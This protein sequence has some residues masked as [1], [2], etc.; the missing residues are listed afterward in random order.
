MVGEDVKRVVFHLVELWFS[1]GG[2]PFTYPRVLQRDVHRQHAHRDPKRY[3]MATPRQLSNRSAILAI[4]A[5]CGRRPGSEA[6]NGSLLHVSGLY[7]PEELRRTLRPRNRLPDMRS[8]KSACTAMLPR[9]LT[10]VG[11]DSIGHRCLHTFPQGAHA[12]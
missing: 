5:P 12:G 1:G 9:F 8:T 6:P 3:T 2:G 4:L 11:D 10:A 7:G